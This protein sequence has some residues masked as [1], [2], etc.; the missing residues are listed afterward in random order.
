MTS[1]LARKRF[2]SQ[3]SNS[4]E[5]LPVLNNNGNSSQDTYGCDSP[6]ASGGFCSSGNLYAMDYSRIVPGR[7][8]S[9][10]VV[11]QRSGMSLSPQTKIRPRKSVSM[12]FSS[13]NGSVG[14]A[15][16]DSAF[17]YQ[18]SYSSYSPGPLARTTSSSSSSFGQWIST[19]V[20][21][22]GVLALSALAASS[23]QHNIHLQ[24]EL[25]AKE[26]Q[27]DLH[28]EHAHA[29]E[30]RVSSMRSE[31]I[32]LKNR[33]SELEN[34][35]PT[36]QELS[37]Q[38]NI[39][40]L[41][42]YQDELHRGLA[43]QSRWLLVEKFG[44][45]PKYYV[46]MKLSFDPESNIVQDTTTEID[47]T[48]WLETADIDEMPHTIHFFLEQVA[49]GVFDNTAFYRNAPRFVQAGPGHDAH[50]QD[51]LEQRQ[52]SLMHVLF[53]EHSPKLNHEQYTLG[54]PERG[55]DFY[56]NL[57]DN[58]DQRSDHVIAEEA[59]PCFARIIRGF[60]TMERIHRSNILEEQAGVRRKQYRMTHPVTIVS[61]KVHDLNSELGQSQAR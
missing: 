17:D 42:K 8:C 1:M 53:R 46:E 51:D 34:P 18:S 14:S 33:I 54:Y 48:I 12:F 45:G 35:K 43:Q 29:L 22:M 61:M 59:D 7:A 15:N 56:L 44:P 11:R 10:S 13:D 23:W 31:T 26:S 5:D 30:G 52:P 39:N 24:Y 2:F 57:Q 38:R 20:A 49:N 6:P 19:L 40:H 28:L 60:N 36:E 47:D 3:S 25:N 55:P 37:M 4:S 50:V 16:S 27:I 21:I 58:S 32:H 41:Q 9:T